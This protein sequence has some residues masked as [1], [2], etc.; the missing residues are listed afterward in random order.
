MI[1]PVEST[2]QRLNNRGRKMK[3]IPDKENK[4]KLVTQI[5]TLSKLF[6]M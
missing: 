4:G 5:L 6:N 3:R 1:Y 2:T